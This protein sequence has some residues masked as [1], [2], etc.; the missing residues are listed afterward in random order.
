MRSL[1][2]GLPTLLDALAESD[3]VAAIDLALA[4][5]LAEQDPDRARPVA[6]AAVLVSALQRAGH[7][8][9]PL[10]VWAG[11][12]LLGT[13]VA[14]PELD[15]WRA[16]LEASPVVGTPG[17]PVLP[18][19]LD[20]DRLALYRLWAAEGRVSASLAARVGAGPELDVEALRPTFAALFPDAASGDRQALAA[21]GALRH[22]LAVVAGGPGTGKT[23][24][25]AKMLA[26][27]LTADPRLD[28]ALAT[29]TGKA[30][31]RLAR[32]IAERIAGLPVA[33]D[34]R[35][36]V[37]T[38]ASTLHRLL[39]YSPSRRRFG[40]TAADPIPADVVVVDE[41]SM[42]DLVLFD[43]LLDA[44]RPDARLVLLGDAD[45]LPSVGAGAVFGDL[46]AAGRP[47]TGPAVVG[48]E[49]A[50]LCA[51]LGVG[52]V[53]AGPPDPVADAVVR[54]TVSHRFSAG[55]GIG[56]LAR[57]L[58]DGDA[59]AVRAVLSPG[60]FPDV[61]CLDGPRDEA[62]WG[63]A[64]GHALRL[65]GATDPDDALTAVTAFRIL[66]P[67]RGGR[68][69]VRALNRLVERRL[70]E[71]GRISPRDRWPH[72]RP[73]L[74]TRN[75]YDRGLFNGDVGVVWRRG[76]RPVVLFDTP[77][78]VR[79][80]SVG[81]LP[82]HETAWAMTVHK[83]QGSEFDDVLFVLPTP[84]SDAEARLTREL[85]YTAVTRAKAQAPGEPAPLTVVGSPDAL[86]EAALRAE[87]RASGVHGR[88][89]AAHREAARRA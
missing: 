40:R 1:P 11:T 83:A 89:A 59:E 77:D 55:S 81:G 18:L 41:T 85:A 30:A 44:L 52:D 8:A 24:T 14:L 38:E 15:A 51:A 12:R 37:P 54:L 68:G 78:G 34:V 17:G 65:C 6:L 4:R 2:H 75:D 88:L 32:S 76:P 36:R 86:A 82:E 56:A 72:G 22:R 67:T 39:G 19:V 60:A 62:V 45:Q 42:A 5:L 20:G 29:P 43:A 27:L 31:D 9:V 50:E 69:G 16:D 80:V 26:L 84:G 23:T 3:D 21:A 46:C 25:V 35:A 71:S 57:A 70:V 49:F 74:V 73:V 48:P 63:H 7:S 47:D 66:S 33:D 10:G 87:A 53:E 61:V 79:E 13:D 28:V 58:R 64:E